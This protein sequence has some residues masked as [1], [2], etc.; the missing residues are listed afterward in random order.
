MAEFNFNKIDTKAK[1]NA[2]RWVEIKLDGEPIGAEFKVLSRHSDLG[3]K[4]QQAAVRA[5]QRSYKK[6]GKFVPPDP[7]DADKDRREYVVALCTDWR[8]P[9]LEDAEGKVPPF[10]PA[11]CDAF[12]AR[13]KWVI[14]QL[15]A[16]IVDEA[17]FLKA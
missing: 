4:L 17:G 14:P 11:L 1:F 16:G 12:L 9:A 3:E 5:V 6:D 2:G 8:G 10:T 15:D 7:A 13:E